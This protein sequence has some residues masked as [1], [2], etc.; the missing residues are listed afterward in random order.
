ME[1]NISGMMIYYYFV[2]RRKL[3]YF[4]NEIRMESDYDAVVLGK[5]L[6]EN[7]YGR[8]QKHINIDNVINIDFIREKNMLHEVKKSRSIE[9]ASVWQVKYY[10][11]YLKKKGVCGLSARIDYPLL[12]KNVDVE[13]SEADEIELERVIREIKET[14]SLD[15]PPEMKKKSICRKCAYADLCLI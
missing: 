8:E 9:E 3:W 14:V 4:S 7:S 13:L 11:Y 5:I 12:H 15:L 2:C 6:D 1:R 10:L